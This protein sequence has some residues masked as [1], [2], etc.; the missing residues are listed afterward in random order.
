MARAS[1]SYPLG[2]EFKSPFRHH[3]LQSPA[4]AGLFIFA[5]S[6]HFQIFAI[7]A[8]AKKSRAAL[9]AYG[10]FAGVAYSLFMDI[11]TVLWYS[12]GFDIELYLLSIKAAIPHTILY[13]VSN[14]IFLLVLAKPFG[15]KLERIKVKYGV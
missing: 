7:R 11:W 14:F 13:A 1:G 6:S 3:R 5:A 12:A 10:V 8:G 4:V 9:A 2:R 15:E